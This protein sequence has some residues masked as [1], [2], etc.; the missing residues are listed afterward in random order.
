MKARVAGKEAWCASPWHGR[1]Q[2]RLF[3]IISRDVE[4][5]RVRA[6]TLCQHRFG[7]GVRS[8]LETHLL[9]RIGSATIRYTEGLP[10]PGCASRPLSTT[11]LCPRVDMARGIDH[12]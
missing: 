4:E 2:A 11:G 5:T 7:A 3:T 1:P 6:S 9:Q 12:A 10:H 8:R